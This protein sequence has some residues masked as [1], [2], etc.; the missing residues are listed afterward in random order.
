MRGAAGHL[1]K[2]MGP[3]SNL[4]LVGGA[5]RDRLLGRQGGDWDLA[6]A[7]LP[8]QMM[9]RAKAA[10]LRVIPTGLQH[11]TVTVMVGQKAFEITTFR[12]DGD[13]KDGRH[14]ESVKLGV[15]LEED[16]ARRD[17]TINAMAISLEAMDREDWRAYLVD[18]F[19]GQRDLE[20]RMLRAVGDPLQRFAEDGLRPLR[21]CRFA[22]Q[23]GFEIE[24]ATFEAIRER[25]DVAKKVAVERVFQEMSKLLCAP[26]ARRGVQLLADSGL[27]DLWMA[28]LRPMIGC[29]PNRKHCFPVWEH[30]L[31]V[32]TYTPPDPA[33]RWAALL[34][35][36]GKPGTLSRDAKGE[37]HY[38]GHEAAS[39]EI[40]ETILL[41][42]RA[43]RTLISE[44]QAIVQHHGTHPRED[45]GDAACRR[46]LGKLQKD[47]LPL[48][49]WGAFR[50]ADQLGKG[51][52]DEPCRS[53]HRAIMARL[54]A[55]LASKPPLDSQALALD[56]KALM[57]LAGRSGGPWLGDLQKHLLDAVL[58]DPALNHPS[59]LATLAEAW[60]ATE[61]R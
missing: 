12:G 31:E 49:R 24:R 43:S 1:L 17:F 23:L 20:A 46:F 61:G 5:L 55:L 28:E 33:M 14:P 38:Y 19:G 6:T 11:G 60:L 16:L 53:E 29:P 22:S 44:V 36:A 52:G 45:W 2:A 58:E 30:A 18:P 9:S 56:G 34:H 15:A 59:D 7:L 54:E 26:E 40:A 25:L 27:L 50:I 51:F 39:H 42:L 35:D 8:D 41:R 21:A 4:V 13:Y 57:K 37:I 3:G 10:G 47:G 48:E 32:L